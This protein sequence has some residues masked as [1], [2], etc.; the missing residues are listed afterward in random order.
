MLTS[1]QEMKKVILLFRGLS[2]I[3]R[4][5]SGRINITTLFPLVSKI[6]RV[7]SDTCES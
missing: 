7:I 1:P 3:C 6:T 4:K 2:R 5:I